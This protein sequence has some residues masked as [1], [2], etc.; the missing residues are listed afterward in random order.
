MAIEYMKAEY[1]ETTFSSNE[2]QDSFSQDVFIFDQLSVGVMSL[3]IKHPFHYLIFLCK[4]IHEL[5]ESIMIENFFNHLKDFL[6]I[7]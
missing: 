7:N 1:I 5:F 3:G 2:V 4:H 6:R